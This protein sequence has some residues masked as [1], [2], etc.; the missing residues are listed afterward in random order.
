MTTGVDDLAGAAALADPLR[1]RIYA[2]VRSSVE[3]VGREQTAQAL[4]IS[5]HV[6]K[7]QLDRLES[8]GLLR[9]DYVRLSGRSGPGAGRPS[10]VYRPSGRDLAVSVP[11]RDYQLAGNLLADAVAASAVSGEDAAAALSRLA[12]DHGRS[13]TAAAVGSDFPLDADKAFALAL[14]ILIDQGYEPRV[15]DG[16]A[17]L[18][19]CPFHALAQRQTGLVCHMNEA[20]IGGVCDG[21][22]PCGPRAALE[23]GPDR[24]C[25]VVSRAT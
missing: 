20:L 13:L 14:D 4:G 5:A 8:A 16:R 12:G 6:A 2:H 11:A 18:S 1:R 10:K 9:A 7:F 23:P 22:G 15:D 19:N 3:P 25:V 17:V 21:L 24:C